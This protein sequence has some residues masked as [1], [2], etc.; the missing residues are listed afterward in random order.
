MKCQWCL[1]DGEYPDE[2]NV[3]SMLQTVYIKLLERL[4]RKWASLACKKETE[5]LRRLLFADFVTFLE[6]ES[7]IANNPTYSKEAL[8]KIASKAKGSER[9]PSRAMQQKVS[10]F[11]TQAKNDDSVPRRQRNSLSCPSCSLDH[12]LHSCKQF[13]HKNP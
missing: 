9:Y 1:R 3:S 11:A 7:D 13:L 8:T 12:D 5:N 2:L 4:Q 6:N 10:S